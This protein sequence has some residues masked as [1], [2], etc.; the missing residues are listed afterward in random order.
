MLTETERK[1]I[2][3]LAQDYRKA[4]SRVADNYND[5]RA[6]AVVERCSRRAGHYLLFMKQSLYNAGKNL[7]DDDIKCFAVLV[8]SFEQMQ[9]NRLLNDLQ[10][11]ANFDVVAFVGAYNRSTE[12][13]FGINKKKD[14]TE[15]SAK[16]LMRRIDKVSRAR[17]CIK[18]HRRTFH[19]VEVCDV[20]QDEAYELVHA[21]V[22]GK[23][24]NNSKEYLE[25]VHK[26]LNAVIINT[27]D[28]DVANLAKKI[29][30]EKIQEMD[31]HTEIEDFVSVYEPEKESN[32]SASDVEQTATDKESVKE[33]INRIRQ[34]IEERK[35][36][37]REKIHQWKQRIEQQKAERKQ[38][39]R[40]IAQERAKQIAEKKAER[41]QALRERIEQIRT[42]IKQDKDAQRA[43]K[44]RKEAEQAEQARLQEIEKQEHQER[45]QAHIDNAKKFVFG[46]VG[47]VANGFA[48]VK[49]KLKSKWQEK[50]SEIETARRN[51]EIIRDAERASREHWKNL[52]QQQPKNQKLEQ[53]QNS[54][55]AVSEKYE[56]TVADV[57]MKVSGAIDKGLYNVGSVVSEIMVKHDD[58][59]AK[60]KTAK[61]NREIIRDAERASREHWKELKREEKQAEEEKKNLGR[62]YRNLFAH[63]SVAPIAALVAVA[64]M[65]ITF[66]PTNNNIPV[67][68]D[69]KNIKTEQARPVVQKQEATTVAIDTAYAEALVNYYNSAL[70]IIGGA[71]KA[72]VLAKINNQVQSGNIVLSDY[73]SVERVA[74]AYF[75][76]REYGFNI[77]VLNLAVN[78]NQKLTDAQMAELNK[79]IVDAGER[80]K[81]VQQMAKQRVEAR[82][83][84][85]GKHSKF[86]NATK[87][88]QRAYLVNRGVLKKVH[89]R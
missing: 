54:M 50:K 14:I 56:N 64:G 36:K 48:S 28:G 16:D 77:D 66:L 1:E 52:E 62:F 10:K 71:K 30:I 51:H 34:K 17:K 5:K 67:K 7:D 80:G 20:I 24:K 47:K 68:S 11:Y 49:D 82:G 13:K 43:E 41:E 12:S 44:L 9:R 69:K 23:L 59:K 87:A 75:I 35:Q 79:V 6:H 38:K 53:L 78:G 86:E 63:P 83:G 18:Q 29:L 31:I 60:R 22:N 73:I 61:Q 74:Y 3:D 4:H 85:L 84:S 26:F 15:L 25:S 32:E 58:L 65:W 39:N 42:T 40:E 81:G 19:S 21:V 45:R 57:A 27:V 70:D 76:Y 89:T 55:Q 72:N 46:A 8:D 88:Q 2:F 33:K 37:E